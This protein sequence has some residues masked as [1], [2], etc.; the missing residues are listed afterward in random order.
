ME[1]HF[2]QNSNI[3]DESHLVMARVCYLFYEKGMTQDRISKLLGYLRVKINQIFK[4]V[5]ESG[6]VEI[7]TYKPLNGHVELYNELMN[8]RGLRNV[9]IVDSADK[10]RG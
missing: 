10:C 4:Q 7:K 5:R 1:K 3:T 2:P 8:L 6:I 9:R